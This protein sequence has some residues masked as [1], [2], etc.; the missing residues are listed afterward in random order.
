ML[1]TA[2]YF[3]VIIADE[4]GVLYFISHYYYRIYT[5]SMYLL[6]IAMVTEEKLYSLT[7][8]LVH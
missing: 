5:Y 3:L 2:R 1:F 7:H 8:S 4:L 6:S